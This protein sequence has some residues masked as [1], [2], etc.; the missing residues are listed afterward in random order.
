MDTWCDGATKKKILSQNTFYRE[1]RGLF[2]TDA[3]SSFS[4][5]SDDPISWWSNFGCEVPELQSF[6]MK[7][8]SQS[9]S[10][11]PC[12]E[13][14]LGHLNS[15]GNTLYSN[16]G[17]DWLQKWGTIYPK[18]FRL[19]F[20]PFNFVCTSHP[21]YIRALLKDKP[22]KMW[23]YKFVV[24]WLGDGLLFSSGEKWFTRR[25]ML[26]PSFHFDLLK[27]YLDIFNET[28]NI[29]VNQLK[30]NGQEPVE[31]FPKAIAMTLDTVL[32]CL[33]HYETN[34][35]TQYD[36]YAAIMYR[37]IIEDRKEAHLR[38]PDILKDTKNLSFLDVIL[39]V[40]MEDILEEANVFILGGHDTTASGMS[41]ILFLLS[42]NPEHMAKC[43]EEIKEVFD[44]GGGDEYVTQQQINDL[45]YFSLCFKE[46]L[47]MKSPVPMIGRE[48]HNEVEID[49]IRLPKG[50]NV[51]IL[52]DALHR[53]EEFWDEPNEFR[54]ERFSPENSKD[55]DPYS[56]ILFSAGS[57]NCIGQ[58]FAIAELKMAVAKLIY[59]FVV[60][61][62]A[63]QPE[64]KTDIWILSGWKRQGQVKQGS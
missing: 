12:I 62:V 4:Q 53:V 45:T 35:Q 46:C 18:L 52:I 32:R 17:A 49:G 33:V 57:R 54:P 60:I 30:E 63:H 7:A 22:K 26:T 6:A 64:K 15:P 10:A 28:T 27:S 16:E 38:N 42:Q 29:M 47:R 44:N 58:N 11:S 41:W 8:L 50:T 55:R 39:T 5:D 40:N 37:K 3:A 56:Y 36:E 14:I 23:F 1:K 48:L 43:Y 21:K 24:D 51:A 13:F 59:N 19:R 9:T 20:G 25:K 34:C 2:S 31:I 61:V